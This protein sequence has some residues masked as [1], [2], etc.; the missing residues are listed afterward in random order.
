MVPLYFIYIDES[1]GNLLEPRQHF[2][3]L[4]ATAIKVDECIAI[5]EKV[6]KLKQEFFPEIRAEDIEVKGYSLEQAKKF[7]KH[8]RLEV[9]REIVKRLLELLMAHDTSLFAT[10]LSKKEEAVQRLDLHP[11]D[12]YRY[13]YKNLV[14]RL[15]GFLESKREYGILLID[16]QASSIRNH[17]K[18]DRLLR[19]HQECLKELRKAGGERRIVEYPL[20]VQSEFFAA[21]QL[22]DL[23]AYH[24]SRALHLR[25][26]K[27]Y[28]KGDVQFMPPIE[29]GLFKN[30]E[31][32]DSL[33][34]IEEINLPVMAKLLQRSGGIEK[35]P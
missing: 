11:D 30:G 16:S 24:I 29:H 32:L 31:F 17:L 28:E 7:F 12:E 15:A 25:Y 22:A 9:R 14:K 19:F 34:S 3:V 2:F 27:P 33:F 23:C 26:G 1:G 20:F 18:D 21:T 6:T 8:V 35:I 10:V 13:A 4:A 5:Q